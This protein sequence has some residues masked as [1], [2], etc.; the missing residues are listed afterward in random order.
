ML[1]AI[2]DDHHPFLASPGLKWY[3]VVCMFVVVVTDEN[4]IFSAVRCAI[5]LKFG[6][7]LGLVFPISV[8][9]LV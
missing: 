1:P 5:E 8:Q 9:V 4:W 3:V 2:H 6:G 7:D